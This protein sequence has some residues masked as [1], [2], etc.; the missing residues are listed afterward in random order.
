MIKSI[1]SWFNNFS[2]YESKQVA[3]E[4]YLSKST[5]HADL[6]YRMRQLDSGNFNGKNHSFLYRHL[7]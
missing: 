7:Y 6:E 3:I 5:D 1:L 4:N 2:T